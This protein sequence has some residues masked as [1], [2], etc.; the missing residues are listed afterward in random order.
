MS[1]SSHFT[2]RMQS[3][4]VAFFKLLNI[5]MGIAIEEKLREKLG[6]LKIQ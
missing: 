3:L 5:Y 6:R 4:D 1:L 2:H